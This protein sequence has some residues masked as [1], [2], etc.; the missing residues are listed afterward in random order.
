MK[1]TKK[2]CQNDSEEDSEDER[3]ARKTKKKKKNTKKTKKDRASCSEEDS[4]EESNAR[5]TKEKKKTKKQS[6]TQEDSQVDSESSQDQSVRE[7]TTQKRKHYSFRKC[8]LC[9]RKVANLTRHVL[10][11]HVQKNQ[12]IPLARAEAIIQMSIHSGKLRGKNRQ[13]KKGGR[14]KSS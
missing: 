12:K 6:D 9:S 5:K 7:N 2:A 14:G 10:E 11:V 3:N 8:V 1:K 13:E 4:E